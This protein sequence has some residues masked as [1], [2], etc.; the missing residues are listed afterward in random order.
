MKKKISKAEQFVAWKNKLERILKRLLKRQIKQNNI[1]KVNLLHLLIFLF[2]LVYQILR[3]PYQIFRLIYQILRIPYQI[4]RLIY[5]IL[6]IPYILI[7]KLQNILLVERYFLEILSTKDYCKKY[8]LEY[9]V[10]YPQKTTLVHPPIFWSEDKQNLIIQEPTEVN[11]PEIHLAELKSVCIYSNSN[12]IK[13]GFTGIEDKINSPYLQDFDLMEAN[14]K[15]LINDSFAY[16]EKPITRKTINID[17]GI[18]LSGGASYNYYHWFTEFLPRMSLIEMSNKYN[19]YPILIDYE[20]SK[21]NSIMDSLKTFNKEN[22]EIIILQEKNEYKI[23]HLVKPSL[24]SW[25]AMNLKENI[26]LKAEHC[27]ISEECINS[28]REA[29]LPVNLNTPFR[30]IYISRKNTARKLLNQNAIIEIVEKYGFEIV[31]PEELSLEEQ[32]KLFSECKILI[33]Q[34]GAGFTNLL[35]MQKNTQ[36]ICLVADKI[37]YSGFSYFSNIASIVGVNLINLAGKKI[38][39]GQR[40]L[41]EDLIIDQNELKNVINYIQSTK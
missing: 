32:V 34:S 41:H 35:F 33:G 19:N 40:C 11:Q 1:F 39:N 27:I 15:T 8:N 12:I 14:I 24:L 13:K 3:I 29:F 9:K 36:A 2:R 7:K 25:M 4:F 5:Q 18:M 10:I 38:K 37:D 6:R 16:C 28:L 30:K 26:I 22:R 20:T 31:Y 23:N 17:K 21:I